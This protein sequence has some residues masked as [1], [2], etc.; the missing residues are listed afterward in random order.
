MMS[1]VKEIH[2]RGSRIAK[3]S[4]PEIESV[5]RGFREGLALGRSKRHS[6]KHTKAELG[7]LGRVESRQRHGKA[8]NVMIIP[9]FSC[10]VIII[11]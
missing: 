3:S 6:F 4:L 10:L 1:I 7:I 11:L 5:G 9:P 2:K 8:L